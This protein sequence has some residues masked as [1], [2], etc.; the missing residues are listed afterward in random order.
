M[1][2]LC[3]ILLLL[4]L[5][6]ILA[7]SCASSQAPADKLAQVRHL[8]ESG[9][10][11]E[12]YEPFVEREFDPS[13][14]GKWIGQAASYGCYRPGQSPG[15]VGPSRAEIKEDLDLI[16]QHWNLIRV[17]N[18]DDD[19]KRILEVIQEN[20]LPIKL[21]LGIWLEKEEN[22]SQ[23]QRRNQEN[24]IRGIH[25]ANQYS[26]IVIAVNV[27]NET[28]VYWSWH[29]MKSEALIR[30]IRAVRSFVSVPV[31]TADDYDFWLDP[32]SVAVADEVDFI[33][34]HIHPLWNGK[35]LDNAIDWLDQ[36]LARVKS[37][38]QGKLIVLGET[39]WATKYDPEKKGE[40]EQGT[41][42][43]GEV[44]EAA[45]ERFLIE[46]DEWVQ[47]K[48]TITFLFE[49]FDEP[50]KGGGEASGPNEIEKN[51][52]VF[53]ADRQPKDS[54]VNYLRTKETNK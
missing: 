5:I 38:H 10:A 36:T 1:N 41:L 4:V 42:I 11:F 2:K 18:A 49:V 54:F 44:D 21:M 53:H 12:R 46:L 40:G 29:K 43:K 34:T 19:T 14:D 47:E 27:G 48:R 52:G 8:L 15:G 31:T 50:W 45:Q 26:D 28:Q 24:V 3:L 6:A 39:G 9:Q 37:A 16:K 22:D 30:Y 33:V 17:Y 7:P 32:E 23:A 35:T 25:L 13:L 20:S 51:W